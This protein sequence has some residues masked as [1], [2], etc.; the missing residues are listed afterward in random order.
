MIKDAGK[1]ITV[2]WGNLLL[3]VRCTPGHSSAPISRPGAIA[4]SPGRPGAKTERT[5]NIRF[6]RIDQKRVQRDEVP[7]VLLHATRMNCLD[8]IQT[9]GLVPGG[10]RG[11]REDNF[12]VDALPFAQE[13]I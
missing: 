8:S 11:S 3:R 9:I 12:F 1:R 10:L 13:L 6:D 7:K 5:P 2:Q 4:A